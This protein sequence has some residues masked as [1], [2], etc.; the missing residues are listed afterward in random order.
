MIADGRT[1]EDVSEARARRLQPPVQGGPRPRRARH[2]RATTVSATCV[3]PEHHQA[4]HAVAAA[5]K[6]KPTADFA[7]GGGDRQFPQAEAS[8]VARGAIVRPKGEGCVSSLGP[9]IGGP[10]G[11]SAP[12]TRTSPTRGLF[13]G[14]QIVV[15]AK[16][17][18]GLGQAVSGRCQPAAER[19]LEKPATHAM[20][21]EIGTSFD[22][23][24]CLEGAH[25]L[26]T[27]KFT[28]MTVLM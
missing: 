25:A 4:N 27:V 22:S 24:D 28:V 1:G 17:C 23:I 26:G 11:R 5:R 10:W 13:F 18:G 2:P 6:P 9:T 15:S 3:G 20:A 19:I 12:V 8:A 21:N 16:P 14:R 7:A